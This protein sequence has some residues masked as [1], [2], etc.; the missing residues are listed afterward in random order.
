M[1]ATIPSWEAIPFYRVKF[2]IL[3]WVF[4]LHICVCITCIPRAHEG[5]KVSVR[6]AR[7][8]DTDGV[9]HHVDA[10]NGILVLWKSTVPYLQCMKQFLNLI[11]CDVFQYSRFVN[12][13]YELLAITHHAI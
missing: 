11:V 10:G 8:K 12:A 2:V 9:S 5:Q 1:C 13:C 4:Y 7:T 3:K 6:S